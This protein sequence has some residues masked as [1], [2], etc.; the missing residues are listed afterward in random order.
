MFGKEYTTNAIELRNNCRV[1]PK[2]IQKLR[3]Q[4]L[5]LENQLKLLKEIASENGITLHLEEDLPAIREEKLKV[6]PIQREFQ[7][8]ESAK[9]D[10]SKLADDKHGFPEEMKKVEIFSDSQE[11]IKKYRDAAAAAQEAFESAA[12][13][14]MAARAALELSRIKLEDEGLDMKNYGSHFTKS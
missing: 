14:A 12:F 10:Q 8:T 2:I 5:S 6:N 13:A 3:A 11:P 7:P 4:Q 9:M 1:N